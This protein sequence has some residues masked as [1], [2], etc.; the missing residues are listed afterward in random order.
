MKWLKS[1]VSMFRANAK[2][3]IGN[4]K[5]EIYVKIVCDET[6]W[7]YEKAKIDMDKYLGMG[8]TY[9]TYITR[10][11]YKSSH[12]EI[13]KK[14]SNLARKESEY[15]DRVCEATGW[16]RELAIREM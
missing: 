12:Q 4:K 7:T 8:I 13:H 9:D 3:P 1:F 16:T 15:I 5:D 11:F 10:A 6:G 2:K 14:L